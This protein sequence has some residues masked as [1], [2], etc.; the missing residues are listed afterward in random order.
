MHTIRL[1]A[2]LAALLLP[3]GARLAAQD[4]TQAS[5]PRPFA[6]DINHR[7]VRGLESPCAAPKG[8]RKVAIVSHGFN[9]TS[10]F[11][12]DYFPLLNLM[13]YTVIA[14]DY[15]SGS[16]HSSSDNNTMNMS[17][18]DQKNDLVAIARHCLADPGVDK[19]GILLF[20]ESQ[21]GL[22]SA[23]AAAELGDSVHALVLFYPALCIPDNWRHSYPTLDDIPD[24]TRVWNVPIGRRFFS[25]IH[26]M[27]PFDLIGAYKGPVEIVH[28]DR[29]QVVIIDYSRRAAT[30][31]KD[32]RVDVIAGAGHGFNPAQRVKAIEYLR[33]F[34]AAHRQK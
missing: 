9:G 25:E 27:E 22:V 29:D 14:P 30:V 28:G 12:R 6:L 11:A 31:Y 7:T 10:A 1:L 33:A 3:L 20:G 17:V 2:L 4:E 21:G 15:P 18:L 8:K 5:A 13:G 16:V 19:H 26:D 23:L 24:T 32:A 34:L